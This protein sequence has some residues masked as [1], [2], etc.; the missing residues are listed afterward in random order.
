MSDTSAVCIVDLAFPSGHSAGTAPAALPQRELST[1]VTLSRRWANHDSKLSTYPDPTEESMST[2]TT[3]FSVPAHWARMADASTAPDLTVWIS[4]A[5]SDPEWDA[6]LVS[7]PAGQY[8]QSSAWG[9]VKQRE[10]WQPT[11]FIVMAGDEIVGGFQILWQ[12]RFGLRFGYVTKG[13]VVAASDRDLTPFVDLLKAATTRLGLVALVVQAPDSA[14]DLDRVFSERG[15]VDH[16]LQQVLDA[17]IMVDLERD[18]AEVRRSYSRSTRKTIRKAETAGITTR[19]GRPEE[20]EQ[21]FNLMAGTCRRIGATPSPSSPAAIVSVLTVFNDLANP[22]PMA[23]SLLLAEQNGTVVAGHLLMRFGRTLSL[24]KTGA[25]ESA[26]RL[27]VA[28]LLNDA[29]FHYAAQVGCTRGEIVG[30]SRAAAEAYLRD[31]SRDDTIIESSDAMK[32][33]FG[34]VP[35]LLPRAKVWIPRRIFRLPYAVAAACHR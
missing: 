31:N 4:A 27:G 14:I 1:L 6:F 10:G 34:G 2:L 30:C 12:R 28:K 5:A 11:R 13:P 25:L 26:A 18:F 9:R 22:A 35:L 8:Q 32:L 17:T 15:F 33:G 21:F 7:T 20:A 16:R 29:S 24:W 19:L 3:S 23:A